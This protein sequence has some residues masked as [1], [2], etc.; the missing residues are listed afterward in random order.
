MNDRIGKFT[1]NYSFGAQA[2][3]RNSEVNQ[4]RRNNDATYGEKKFTLILQT[5]VSLKF[6]FT[7]G[8]PLH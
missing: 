7:A 4:R 8:F 6:G 2:W 3:T 5:F 1:V